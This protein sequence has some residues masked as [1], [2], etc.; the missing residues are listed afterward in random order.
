MGVMPRYSNEM[1]LV[2]PPESLRTGMG[3]VE[4]VALFL[5]SGRDTLELAHQRK[6]LI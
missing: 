6:L 5:Q 1:E 2:A 3:P 4:D